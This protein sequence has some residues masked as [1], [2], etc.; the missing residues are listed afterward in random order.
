MNDHIVPEL[1]YEDR[2]GLF[3]KELSKCISNKTSLVALIEN[4]KARK[5]KWE[6][7]DAF[8][9]DSKDRLW[10][11]EEGSAN[12]VM[13]AYFLAKELQKEANQPTVFISI[14]GKEDYE[15][16]YID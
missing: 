6:V 1:N 3:E 13:E 5:Y 14:K 8:N 15:L 9:K 16:K 10:S 11:F 7:I 4:P 2:L 12:A